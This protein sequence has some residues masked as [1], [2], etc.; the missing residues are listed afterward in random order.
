MNADELASWYEAHHQYFLRAEESARQDLGH[1]IEDWASEHNFRVEGVPEVRIKAAPRLLEKVQRKGIDDLTVLLADPYP[2]RDIVGARI[3]VRGANDYEALRQA[4]EGN[5]LAWTVLDVDDKRRTPSK[6]GYRALH[7]DC[8]VNTKVRNEE[9]AIPVE[10][11]I[12]TLA[13][14]VWGEFTHDS[15]YAMGA[16]AS[17]ARFQVVRAL[18]T[19]VAD[20]LEIVDQ[21]Q[22][23]IERISADVM[24]D[25]AEAPATD[26]VSVPSVLNLFFTETE[27]VLPL[28][29]AQTIVE[30]SNYIGIH[31]IAEIRDFISPD[32]AEALE[33]AEEW[34]ASNGGVSPSPPELAI[35]LL[36]ARQQRATFEADEG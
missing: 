31:R 20:Q 36:R 5:T 26:E 33:V 34:R 23:T 17:D 9:M 32:S 30:V 1:L 27:M 8:L 4:L 25:I 6:T 21:L 22:G 13:Q 12:K 3:V 10:L 24:S 28:A 16:V 14:K 18:Q 35:E 2:I 19:T 7:L 29:Q 15:A 11:Q